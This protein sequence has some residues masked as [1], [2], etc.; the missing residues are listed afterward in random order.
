MRLF[1]F[2]RKLYEQMP[3]L[4]E[5]W[6]LEDQKGEDVKLDRQM[7]IAKESKDP[8]D[9]LRVT[10]I[11]IKNKG[12]LNEIYAF[13][14]ILRAFLLEAQSGEISSLKP[15]KEHMVERI[16]L[17]REYLLTS[18]SAH[19]LSSP[20]S[21]SLARCF[22]L[23]ATL[24]GVPFDSERLRKSAWLR[25]GWTYIESKVD[26]VKLNNSVILG[27][28]DED[29]VSCLKEKAMHTPSVYH[30]FF[31]YCFQHDILNADMKSILTPV[32]SFDRAHI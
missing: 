23:G 29:A 9:S 8:K 26:F 18:E 15:S 31:S 12:D 24:S 19:G 27:N 14:W 10:K 25:E 4:E 11:L 20:K 28:I 21:N 32:I 13:A 30:A 7:A 2:H 17:K 5:G 1:N 3:L 16:F 22:F 6:N